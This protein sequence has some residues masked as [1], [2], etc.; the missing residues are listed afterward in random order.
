MRKVHVIVLLLFLP[1]FLAAQ[2][3]SVC[4]PGQYGTAQGA[5]GNSQYLVCMPQPASC[6]KG[7][8]ILFAHG[9]VP[10]GSPANAWL[11]QLALP[12]G[13]TLPGL[14]NGLG[15]GFAAS[16]FSKDGLAILQ[17]IQD[18][19][20]LTNVI[21]GL[22]IPVHK[23]FVTGASEGGLVAT[24]SVES[25]PS[26]GGGLAVCGP[27]GSFRSQINY[28]GDV[29]V[30]FDYFFPGVLTTGTAGESAI[31]IPPVLMAD[32]AT[33]YEPAVR[34]AVNS[35]F[36]A[37]LQLIST[38]RIPIGLNFANAPDAITGA[39]WYNVFATNDA[40][41]T[42]GGNPYDNIGRVYSGSFNDARLNTMVARFAADSAALTSLAGYETTGLLSDPLVTLH[43][44][45]DPIVPFWQETL[46]AAK[47]KAAGSSPELNQIPVLAYGHCNVNGTEAEAALLLLLLKAGL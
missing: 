27:I 44:T 45:A 30:L 47:A 24:K 15:F 37:T 32:W 35:N 43:T 14:V 20:A 34:K 26:Y 9:Y 22:G 39:L 31:N 10:Q 42:L 16:S 17:G 19:K 38:A 6:Y 3:S 12:D 18:T 46:Y 4:V 13:T 5:S 8:M 28:F 11:S 21:S 33:V 29:R 1:A 7:D 25:D 2:C 36:L 40:K 41:A 23:Y